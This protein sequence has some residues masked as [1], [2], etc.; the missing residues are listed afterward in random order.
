MSVSDPLRTLVS[1]C[2]LPTDNV[3]TRLFESIEHRDRKFIFRLWQEPQRP[4]TAC[5]FRSDRQRYDRD[6]FVGEH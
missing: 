6:G 5:N 3:E 4:Q 2:C 1:R